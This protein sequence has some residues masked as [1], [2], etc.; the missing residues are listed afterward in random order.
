[1]HG[2]DIYDVYMFEQ[3]HIRVFVHGWLQCTHMAQASNNGVRNCELFLPCRILK[4]LC[5]I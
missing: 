4:I 2:N 5:W 1:M 3:V